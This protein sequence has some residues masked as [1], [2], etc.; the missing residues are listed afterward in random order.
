MIKEIMFEDKERAYELFKTDT[1]GF[2]LNVLCGGVALFE[3]T[4][5]LTAEDL[6][7]YCEWGKRYLDD[8]AQKEWNQKGCDVCRRAWEAGT[9]LPEIAVS[10]ERNATLRRCRECGTYWEEFESFADT[11]SIEDVPRCYANALNQEPG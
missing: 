4:V 8:L 5:K 1:G 11:I 3:K 6:R 9:R 2:Y 10:I 7:M